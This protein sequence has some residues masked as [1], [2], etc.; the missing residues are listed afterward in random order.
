MVSLGI[1]GGEKLKKFL[2]EKVSKSNT[3]LTDL[4]KTIAMKRGLN[5]DSVKRRI[6]KW[7][8]T[9]GGLRVRKE[10]FEQV[11][12]EVG[13]PLVEYPYLP[14]TTRKELM[15]T[16]IG[17]PLVGNWITFS[18]GVNGILQSTRVDVWSD[19]DKLF[20]CDYGC[21]INGEEQTPYRSLI[22]QGEVLRFPG[23]VSMTLSCCTRPEVS[24]RL[25]REPHQYESKVS[26]FM[27][28]QHLSETVTQRIR[29]HVVFATK[30]LDMTLETARDILED[31]N[32]NQ[33][34]VMGSLGVIHEKF[35][36]GYQCS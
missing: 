21:A 9:E 5:P 24:F 16:Y 3:N 27:T 25:F 10:E 34:V 13:C 15:K 19:N 22:Y 6:Y 17:D 31:I 36:G 20:C 18:Y 11:L 8:A 32:K 4:A 1:D 30:D 2:L 7:F 35:R 28:G 14:P 26:D 23:C 12:S 33:T 29:S